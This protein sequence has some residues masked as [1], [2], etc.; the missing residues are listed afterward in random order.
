MARGQASGGAATTT[1]MSRRRGRQLSKRERRDVRWALDQQPAGNV[2]A[3][4]VHG[5]YVVFHHGRHHEPTTQPTRPQQRGE[6]VAMHD[7]QRRRRRKRPRALD[8][9]GH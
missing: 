5:V 3:M 9:S 4:D 7:T 6:D 8:Q 1:G 2:H